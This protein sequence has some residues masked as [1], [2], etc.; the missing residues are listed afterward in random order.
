MNPETIL[1]LQ[2]LCYVL[3]GIMSVAVTILI[4]IKYLIP[5]TAKLKPVHIDGALYVLIALFGAVSGIF[6]SDDAYKYVNPYV[7]FWLKAAVEIALAGVGSLKMFRSTSY[8]EHV[9]GKVPPIVDTNNNPPP[10]A[11]QPKKETTV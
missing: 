4:G 7:I 8:A 10:L 6:S 1:N 11:E 9:A 5:E 2:A 3:A